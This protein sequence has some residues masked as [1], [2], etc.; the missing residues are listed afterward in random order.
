MIKLGQPLKKSLFRRCLNRIFSALARWSPGSTTLRPLLHRLRG[1]KVG[2]GV[3]IGEDVYIDNEYPEQIEIQNHVQ[4]SIRA[5]IVAHTRGTGRV[6]IEKEAF[7]GPH[8][9][10]ACSAGRV[11]KIGQG[12]VISAGCVVTKNVPPRMILN[13]AP[14][15]AAGYA[16]TP[17]STAGTMQEFWSGLRP[18]DARKFQ[19]RSGKTASDN[20][21]D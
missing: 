11:L 4:I 3:F 21:Q 15:Q 13:P 20:L 18:L 16:T 7:V 14:A 12:A 10:I 8:V 1:V 6:I 2:K 17:L 9:V 5:V 19:T